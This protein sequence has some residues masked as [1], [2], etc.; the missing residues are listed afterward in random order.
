VNDVAGLAPAAVVTAGKCNLEGFNRI[1][2]QAVQD[3]AGTLVVS[4]F[5]VPQ[6]GLLAQYT[7]PQDLSQ[8]FAFVYA[9]DIIM[10]SPYVEITFTNGGAPST[11]FRAHNEALPYGL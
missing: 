4:F 6:G 8:V 9:Y 11:F 10:L 5:G 2:G 1:R 3:V 7:V